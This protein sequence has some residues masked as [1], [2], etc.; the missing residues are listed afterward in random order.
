MPKIGVNQKDFSMMSRSI[1]REPT[2]HKNQD[3]VPMLA[4][5]PIEDAFAFNILAFCRL[6]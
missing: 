3:D 2:M 6:I 5:T 4:A 1:T